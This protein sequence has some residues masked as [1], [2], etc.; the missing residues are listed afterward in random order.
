MSPMLLRH[1]Q[2]VARRTAENVRA[3]NRDLRASQRAGKRLGARLYSVRDYHC[4]LELTRRYAC[5]RP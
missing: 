3:D 2:G 5:S 4:A 1:L